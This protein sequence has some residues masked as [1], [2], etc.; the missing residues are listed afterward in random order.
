M[1][2]GRG[3][4]GEVDGG[5]WRCGRLADFMSARS[6]ARGLE[7]SADIVAQLGVGEDGEALAR[8]DGS[9]RHLG[10]GCGV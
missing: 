7:G 8:I 10:G 9:L 6:D 2:R 3:G 4:E 1:F 5:G